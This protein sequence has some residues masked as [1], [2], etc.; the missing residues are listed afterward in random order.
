MVCVSF[1]L[2]KLAH[3]PLGVLQ[4]SFGIMGEQYYQ[5]AWGVDLSPVFIDPLVEVRKG[6]SSG[7]TL[8]RDY[9]MDEAQ[10][11]IYEIIDELAKKLRKAHLA[12]STVS[13]TLRYNRLKLIR[14]FSRSTTL[15]EATEISRPLYEACIRLLQ[16]SN[17]DYIR[18]MSV[19]VSNLVDEHQVQLAL[20]SDPMMD[21]LRLLGKTIDEIHQRY[22]PASI[23]RAASIGSAGLAMNRTHRIGGHYE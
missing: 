17:A 12:A 23:V 20:F 15:P 22:G 10:V 6:F 19:G 8:I 4:S 21:E 3:T 13:L 7:R 14:T 18:Y 5:H 11:V 2:G 9:T 1:T 16:Q